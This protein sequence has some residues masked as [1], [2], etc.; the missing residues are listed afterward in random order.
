MTRQLPPTFHGDVNSWAREITEY[1]Q[2]RDG[3]ESEVIPKTAFLQHQTGGERAAD[4]GLLMYDPAA[5]FA[6]MSKGGGWVP[7]AFDI[8][9]VYNVDY[10]DVTATDTWTAFTPTSTPTLEPGTYNIVIQGRAT[11]TGGNASLQF[12]YVT[13]GTPVATGPERDLDNGDSEQV[14]DVLTLTTA[15]G[16]TELQV[17][18]NNIL[19]ENFT[20]H[21]TRIGGL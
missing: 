16:S 18:G 14:T 12:R 13:D 6:V 9:Y 17:R 8:S 1:L 19:L 5:G 4:D 11:A 10:T 15:A 3:V 20:A 21:M 7:L 2:N